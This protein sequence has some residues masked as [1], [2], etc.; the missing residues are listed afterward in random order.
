MN[1]YVWAAMV[2]ASI[3]QMSGCG[4][5]FSGTSEEL[6]FTTDPK[7]ASIYLNERHLG[8]GQITMEVSRSMLN[9]APTVRVEREGYKTQEFRLQTGFNST[10][11][12]NLTSGPSWTTDFVTGGMFEYAPNQYHIQLIKQGAAALDT[13][14]QISRLVL[15]NSDAFRRELALGHGELIESVTALAAAGD[16]AK[17]ARARQALLAGRHALISS[18]SPMELSAAVS[19]LVI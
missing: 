4:T 14:Q 3:V 1:R 16:H 6:S 11:I 2:I 7:D 8:R 5:L 9:G 17:R 13:E 12:L 10:S 18:V 15:I 19:A